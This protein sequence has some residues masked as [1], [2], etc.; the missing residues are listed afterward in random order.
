M[1]VA[2]PIY[3]SA[4]FTQA[5]DRQEGLSNVPNWLYLTGSVSQLDQVWRDY[6]VAVE[7][8][9]AGSMVDHSDLALVIDRNGHIR[10]ELG[11]DP[12]PGTASTQSSYSVWLTQYARQALSES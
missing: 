11:A 12:G 5:F 1:N 9:P 8:L 4:T 10:E 3:R 6:G 7:D 2:N